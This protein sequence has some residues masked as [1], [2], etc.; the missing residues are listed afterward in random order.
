MSAA[1]ITPSLY[2]MAITEVPVTIGELRSGEQE[3]T[4]S[5][6]SSQAREVVS[7]QARV[8]FGGVG[9]VAIGMQLVRAPRMSESLT[10][11]VCCRPA[12]ALASK[13]GTPA[14]D[15]MIQYGQWEC[16]K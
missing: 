15:M 2:L 1:S 10:H 9:C 6:G 3:S 12:P 5:P 14:D 16:G 4:G 8:V 13:T 11:V 7:C